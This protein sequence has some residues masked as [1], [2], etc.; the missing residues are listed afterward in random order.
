MA[1]PQASCVTRM[2]VINIRNTQERTMKPTTIKIEID[3][4]R[5]RAYIASCIRR[6]TSPGRELSS[7]IQA[8][9]NTEARRAVAQWREKRERDN[10]KT[11]TQAKN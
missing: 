5:A 1:R 4:E 7:A 10:D 11:T 8:I 6:G 9:L 3:G 2:R